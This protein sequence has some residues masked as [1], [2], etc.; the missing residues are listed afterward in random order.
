MYRDK[1]CK[2]PLLLGFLV[3][4]LEVR[5]RLLRDRL[6]HKK[7]SVSRTCVALISC[8]Q[9]R[10]RNF[11]LGMRSCSIDI[12]IKIIPPHVYIH[13]LFLLYTYTIFYLI[14]Y[15]YTH[16]KK[17]K[18]SLIFSIKIIFNGD[19]HKINFIFTIFTMKFLKSFIF[20]TN[21]QILY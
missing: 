10:V 14:S 20:N 17:K 3:E 13:T 2:A 19:F 9:G 12:F 16:P 11:C 4:T 15:I 21:Y 5:E 7:L 1:D 18:K 8:G 6:I